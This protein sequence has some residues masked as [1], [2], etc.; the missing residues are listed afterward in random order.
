MIKSPTLIKPGFVL[1]YLTVL[2]CSATAAGQNCNDLKQMA[3]LIGD[4]TSESDTQ[5]ITESWQQTSALTFE[6][7]GIT[8]TRSN[9]NIS[10]EWLRLLSMKDQIFYLAKVD[11]NALPVP[12]QLTG[13]A[14][15][16]LTFRNP[17]HDF[18]KK[19]VYQRL[20]N[21]EM[22]VTVSDGESKSFV[23]DFVKE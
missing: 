14:D 19:I 2:L 10:R 15:D 17:Q 5:V 1:V 11:H 18:P 21:E 3:W 22:K 7:V 6:G 20:N 9:N 8:I 13:C 23:I 16:T 12:F 4:W